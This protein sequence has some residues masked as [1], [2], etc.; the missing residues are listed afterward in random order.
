M[1]PFDD[2][3][4]TPPG[5]DEAFAR[6][7]FA[8]RHQSRAFDGLS[9]NRAALVQNAGAQVQNW[10]NDTIQRGRKDAVLRFVESTGL[11][12]RTGKTAN[13]AL[14]VLAQDAGY[15]LFR[16]TMA[17]ATEV[18]PY[19]IQAM[20]ALRAFPTAGGI[21][22]GATSYQIVARKVTGQAN[23]YEGGNSPIPETNIGHVDLELPIKPIVTSYRWTIFQRLT[24][25]FVESSGSAVGDFL[26]ESEAG[27]NEVIAAQLNRVLWI[28]SPNHKVYG[29]LTFPDVPRRFLNISA[30]TGGTALADVV[31]ALAAAINYAAEQSGLAFF[32]DRMALPGRILNF[33]RTPYGA[34]TP[35]RSGLEVLLS[36]NSYITNQDQIIEA[37]ELQGS[38]GSSRIDS[39]ALWRNGSVQAVWPGGIQNLPEQNVGFETRVFKFVQTG[40]LKFR[41]TGSCSVVNLY[42]S[43]T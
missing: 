35:N 1:R 8:A 15:F 34:A 20:T 11:P 27:A 42:G 22:E 7:R 12:Q 4:A 21:P 18:E 41:N 14:E 28:G 40:G 2:P 3:F 16:E 6:A 19:L 26:S 13:D 32:P 30:Y 24:A 37:P 33:L 25:Q 10:I 39:I 36:M 9:P 29:F 43:A 17:R 5:F 31:A 23:F 38:G